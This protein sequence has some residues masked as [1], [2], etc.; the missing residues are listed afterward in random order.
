MIDGAI[1]K[2]GTTINARAVAWPLDF[3][4]EPQQPA[5]TFKIYAKGQ[6]DNVKGEKAVDTIHGRVVNVDLDVEADGQ[7]GI[8]DDDEP[9]EV[10]PGG[11]ACVCTNNLT[12]INLTLA[13]AGLPGTLTLSATM[14]GQRIKVWE[15]ANRTGE[16]VLPKAWNAGA[17]IPG[18]LYVEGITNSATARDVE[19][20]LER[21]AV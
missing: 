3:T 2:N 7:P 12:P 11:F 5:V 6:V 15:N 4:V 20:R 14:G 21:M 13:P 10:N 17:T 16:I 18:T 19:L 9:E 1:F 8:T